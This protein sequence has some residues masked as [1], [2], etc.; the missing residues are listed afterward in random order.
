MPSKSKWE[1]GALSKR[2][3]KVEAT[4]RERERENGLLSYLDCNAAMSKLD[5]AFD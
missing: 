2:D 5:Q 3:K 4:L 1:G